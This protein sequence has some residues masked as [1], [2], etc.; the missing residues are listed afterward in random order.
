MV[1]DVGCPCHLAH[2]AAEKE[3]NMF[4]VRAEEIP[5]ARYYHF[6][7]SFKRKE[8]LRK[9]LEFACDTVHKVLKHV[10]TRWLSLVKCINRI[11]DLWDGLRP[12]A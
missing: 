12:Y 10:S 6:E 9:Y 1:F 8:D 3:A 7:K 4:S 11:L 5:I 2:I